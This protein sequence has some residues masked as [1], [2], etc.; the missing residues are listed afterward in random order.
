MCELLLT[1]LCEFETLGVV[2]GFVQVT[3]SCNC[4]L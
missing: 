4:Y 2:G 3:V 1:R